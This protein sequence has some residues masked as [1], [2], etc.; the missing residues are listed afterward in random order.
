[1]V[2]PSGRRA[3]PLQVRLEKFPSLRC[4]TVD[5]RPKV[6]IDLE[7]KASL[8]TGDTGEILMNNLETSST[9]SPSVPQTAVRSQ[10]AGSI[11]RVGIRL[12][13]VTG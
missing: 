7:R 11:L 3:A 5:Q 4:P 12:R 10:Q 8:M 1:M 9:Q 2:S 13:L 6:K